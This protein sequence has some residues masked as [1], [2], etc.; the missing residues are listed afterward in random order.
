M[1]IRGETTHQTHKQTQLTPTPSTPAHPKHTPKEELEGRT[2]NG[3]PVPGIDL[4]AAGILGAEAG[5]NLFSAPPSAADT[6]AGAAGEGVGAGAGAGVGGGA[7]LGAGAGPSLS[8]H[9][10]EDHLLA[11]TLQRLQAPPAP[12]AA[13]A[14]ASDGS[15]D[16]DGGEEVSYSCR[17]SDFSYCDLESSQTLMDLVVMERAATRAAKA[18]AGEGAPVVGEG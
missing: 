1:P 13:A 8:S 11:A 14:A 12:L 2:A 7:G 16:G 17:Y 6:H 10:M 18:G 3:D 5:S 4:S 9:E 15:D